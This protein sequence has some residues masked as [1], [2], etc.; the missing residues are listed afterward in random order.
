MEF[1]EGTGKASGAT[2]KTLYD[3]ALRIAPVKA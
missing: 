1:S 2:I 3:G